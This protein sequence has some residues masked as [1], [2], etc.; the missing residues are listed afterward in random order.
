MKR[1]I[2]IAIAAFISSNIYARV[3]KDT[4]KVVFENEKMKVTEYVSSPGADV[5]GKGVHSHP[6]HLN[7]LFTDAKVSL[8]S[9]GKT[10]E[11]SLPAGSVFWSEA[12]THTAINNGKNITRLYIIENKQ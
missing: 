10:Q 4:I 1:I 8:T 7:I 5:C 11:V 12:D 9:G 6:S 2:A 3:S